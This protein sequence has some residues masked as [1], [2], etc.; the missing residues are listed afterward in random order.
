MKGA[1]DP[2]L[3]WT[4]EV[5]Q[6]YVGFVK[7]EEGKQYLAMTYNVITE[8]Y[9]FF[10]YCAYAALLCVFMKSFTWRLR[11]VLLTLFGFSAL[12]IFPGFFF[13]GHYWI[14]VLPG[15]AIAAALTAYMAIELLGR[16]VKMKPLTLKAGIAGLF[17]LV[18]VVHLNK[19]KDYYFNPN[20]DLV[21]R[22]VYGNNPF[23]ETRR[24]A[25]FI[26][27]N[28]TPADNIVS[29]G[30]E[31][32]LY[33][34]TN[35]NCP[36]KHAFFSALV[37]KIPEHKDWQREF[38]ADVEKAR[39]RYIVFYNHPIS[40][41]VQPESDRSIW[42]WYDKYIQDYNIIGAVE[43]VDGYVQ[44]NYY[45]KEQL[46]NFKPQSQTVIYIYER[47]SAS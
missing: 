26:N 5:P 25:D 3:Y 14:Q 44:S 12:T 15:L 2:M 1:M 31:P 47:K 29:I 13:Y 37:H 43:M 19:N 35:K 45:W 39:P 9:K 11:I 33:F 24:I 38:I 30:S 27:A 32:Q 40:L 36:S 6:K 17:L 21:L 18:T 23:P 16:Y 10:W 42:T 7:W 4:V 8:K 20:Y 46:A 34:Y 22:S 41:L 28:S